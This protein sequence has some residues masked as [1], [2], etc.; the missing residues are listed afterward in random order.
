MT[1]RANSPATKGS[2]IHVGLVNNM[3]DSSLEATERQF[4]T[5]LCE[6]ADGIPLHFSLFAIP[7]VR[8]SE[9][10][11]LK[12]GNCYSSICELWDS[13]LDGL[14]VTGAEPVAPNLID[15]PYWTTLAEL[16]D[17]AE[18]NTCSAIWSCLAAHA[19]VLQMDGIRRHRFEEK[20]FGVF[21]GEKISEH[22]LT[23]GTRDSFRMPHSRWNDI[24]QD[25]LVAC[26]YSI[27]TRLK[28]GIVDAFV[29]KRKSL[30]VFF[31][32][33]PEY[34]PASLLFEYRRDIRRYLNRERE[35][36]PSM[37]Q[38]YFDQHVAASFAELRVQALGNR[39]DQCLANFSALSQLANVKSTWRPDAVRFYRN[40][41][42]YV[43]EQKT[44]RIDSQTRLGSEYNSASSVVAG[45]SCLGQ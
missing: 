10:G 26:G 9:K 36:Y 42:H 39:S 7:E 33:H 14:I 28:N 30:F 8:R 21:E 13:R 24:R 1:S 44:H 35:L 45:P 27:L 23:S 2:C 34:E 17:W 11:R 6:A 38:G 20:L 40:W 43:F 15:E 18:E 22:H 19:A 32:G 4:R 31:Q 25:E 5:L 12:I 37:P 41:L 3:P 16:V 29:K